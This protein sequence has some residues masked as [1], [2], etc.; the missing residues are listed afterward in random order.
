MSL[1]DFPE[2]STDPDDWDECFPIH[3][4]AMAAAAVVSLLSANEDFEMFI[5]MD[6]LIGGDVD[7]SE[8]RTRGIAGLIQAG[9]LAPCVPEDFDGAD[10]YLWHFKL[11]EEFLD[12]YP[13]QN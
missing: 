3:E 9:Y 11:S 5:S 12:L 6:E 1:Y 13:F 7:R 4:M 2:V 10:C 8:G